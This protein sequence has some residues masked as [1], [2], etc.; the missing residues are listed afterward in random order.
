MLLAGSRCAAI[1]PLP[2]Q[3]A[4]NSGAEVQRKQVLGS[5]FQPGAHGVPSPFSFTI[6][7]AGMAAGSQAMLV[8]LVLLGELCRHG[9]CVTGGKGPPCWL[10]PQQFAPALGAGAGI[11]QP[12]WLCW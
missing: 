11:A 1:N 7:A 6:V 8:L 3:E 12:A 4:D 5:T 10:L 9:G 2:G